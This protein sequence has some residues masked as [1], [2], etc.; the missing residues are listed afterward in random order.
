MRRHPILAL[1]VL[2]PVLS[3]LASCGASGGDDKADTG[4]KTTTTAAASDDEG[5][6]EP[7]DDSGDQGGDQGD[8]QGGSVTSAALADILPTAEDIGPE[9]SLSD[10]DLTDEAD[11]DEAD[12]AGDEEEAD[13]TEQAIIDA[14]PGAE[15]LNELDND[16]DANADEVSREFETEADATIEVALDP[17]PDQFDEETVGK[18][19]D[20]LSDCGTI[21]TEDDEGNAITMEISAE[22][23]DEFGDFGLTMSMTAEFSAMG[24][25][26]PIEFH[27]L[28]FSVGGT[29][30]S[31]VATSG[32]DDAT[33]EPVAGDYDLIPDLGGLMQERVESL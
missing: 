7:V 26:I 13:P 18:V 2:V 19:V 31:V 32:L 33:F 30:V 14:C 15:I 8:D 11:D 25:T 27:G 10:E 24:M 5:A 6:D 22:E 23:T 21:E 9:Y 28:I 12:D 29:T 1:L 20:A 3:L 4:D 17:T 16:D